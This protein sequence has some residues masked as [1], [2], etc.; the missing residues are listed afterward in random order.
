[1]TSNISDGVVYI[2]YGD[3]YLTIKEDIRGIKITECG[4]IGGMAVIPS[5]GNLVIITKIKTNVC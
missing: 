3:M 1:M 2:K 4:N 5:S